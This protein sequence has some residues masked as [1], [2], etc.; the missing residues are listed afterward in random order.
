MHHFWILAYP[1]IPIETRTPAST[2]VTR[3]TTK[4]PLLVPNQA[5]PDGL[6]SVAHSGSKNWIARML[7]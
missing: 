7:P 1:A 3:E 5:A 2:M 4:I 6:P